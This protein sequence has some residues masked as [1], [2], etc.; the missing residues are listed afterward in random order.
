M[1]FITFTIGTREANSAGPFLASAVVS[2][3]HP[4][5]ISGLCLASVA[6]SYVSPIDFLGVALLG[7]LF[8][9]PLPL[10]YFVVA[11]F[12]FWFIVISKWL[13][14]RGGYN[15]GWVYKW[16]WPLLVAARVCT[17]DA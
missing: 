11:C 14:R 7:L 8:L 9:M 4:M 17:G 15:R 5:D 6:L 13:F 16:D 10:K 12:F 2:S 1:N 3:A